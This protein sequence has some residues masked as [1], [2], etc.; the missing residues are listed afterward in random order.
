MKIRYI[1]SC[2]ALLL[3]T[4][5]MLLACKKDESNPAPSVMPPASSTVNDIDGNIYPTVQIGPQQ[6]LAENLRTTRYQNG[7]M[8][9]NIPGGPGWQSSTTGAWSNYDNDPNLDASHGKLF[10]WYAAIDTRGVCPLGWHVPTDT[11]WQQLENS[12]GMSATELGATGYRGTTQNVGGQMKRNTLWD[13]PNTGAT[14][15]SGFSGIPGG[16]INNNGNFLGT[17]ETDGFWWSRSEEMGEFNAWYRSLNYA[18][19]GIKREYYP[20]N[21]GLCIRCVRD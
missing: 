7:D 3:A 16:A 15:S 9:P 12:L 4:T 21:G 11:D 1:K 20:K 5:T 19:G 6:W 18:N 13:I 17:F 14:N 8:I 2:I 10:N